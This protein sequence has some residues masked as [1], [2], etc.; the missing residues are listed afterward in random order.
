MGLSLCWSSIFN[1]LLYGNLNETYE[2][3]N[4]WKKRH[5]EAYFNS[6]SKGFG[7]EIDGKSILDWSIF[8]K[9]FKRGI[10]I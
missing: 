9:N 10:K 2:I 5:F 4:K 7:T 3:I 8:F 6:P 1:R